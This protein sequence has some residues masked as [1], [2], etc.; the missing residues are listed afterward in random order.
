MAFKSAKGHI[1]FLRVNDLGHVW[2]PPT[3][4]LHTE[5]TMGLDSAP[6]M[7]FGMELRDGDANLPSRLGMLGVLRDAY[8]HKLPVSIW[9]D[10]AEGKKN[11]ILRRVQLG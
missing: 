7:G 9:F 2:G 5:V 8:V 11:G 6:D 3:D 1:R 10:I 4:A